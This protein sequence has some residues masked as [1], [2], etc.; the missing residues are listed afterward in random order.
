VKESTQNS[1]FKW[2]LRFRYLFAMLCGA[3]L[4]SVGLSVGLGFQKL[5]NQESL[6]HFLSLVSIL[7]GLLLIIV[8]FYI[9]NDIEATISRLKL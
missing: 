9:K 4:L 5:S 7:F 3:G 2:T 8:G 1:I 6:D